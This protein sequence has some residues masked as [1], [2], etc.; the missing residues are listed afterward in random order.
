MEDGAVDRVE[1]NNFFA[2]QSRGTSYGPL[3]NQNYDLIS[4]FGATDQIVFGCNFTVAAGGWP[5]FNLDK[6]AGADI[7]FQDGGAVVEVVDL[8]ENEAGIIDIGGPLTK[9][10][11]KAAIES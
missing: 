9:E 8:A 7:D 3:I 2:L 1:Y 4:S 10:N 5:A 6:D 11:V